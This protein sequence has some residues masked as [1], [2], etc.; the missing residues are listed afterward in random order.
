MKII[1]R[2]AALSFVFL[3]AN[4]AQAETAY[5]VDQL[6]V[7]LHQEKDINSPISKVLATGTEVE[8]L[9][10]EGDYAEIRESDEGKTGWVDS[11]Y[12][13]LEL[14]AKVRLAA[15]Q[16]EMNRLKSQENVQ[17]SQAQLQE[18]EQAHAE[19]V[20]NLTTQLDDVKQSL[21]S[22]KLKVGE[23]EA[24]ISQQEKSLA[25]FEANGSDEQLVALQEKNKALQTELSA[26]KRATQ[27]NANSAD[28]LIGA[29]NPLHFLLNRYVQVGLAI[30]AF[31]AFFLGRRWED[32]KIRKR[33]GGF[34][35]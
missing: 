24:T 26:A 30:F 16:E 12:L 28:S 18:S 14:P 1:L 32:R 20:S 15:L 21:S 6:L 13:M 33:H 17:T 23:L 25:Q 29:D 4:T 10:R 8:I 2:G 31:L 27:G 9:R 11:S 35:I 5:I 7:G 19:A 3:T 34:R 22:E